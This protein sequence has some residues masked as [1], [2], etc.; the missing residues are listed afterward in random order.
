MSTLFHIFVPD[1]VVIKAV[2]QNSTAVVPTVGIS[3]EY[4]HR[5][6]LSYDVKPMSPENIFMGLVFQLSTVVY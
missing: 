5:N 6:I 1:S 4:M 3:K 2:I